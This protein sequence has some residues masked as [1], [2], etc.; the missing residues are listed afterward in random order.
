MKKSEHKFNKNIKDS[1]DE[2][3]K[4]KDGDNFSF[5]SSR[6]IY[7]PKSKNKLT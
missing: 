2:N 6:P 3:A 1:I 5:Y 7:I 4:Q